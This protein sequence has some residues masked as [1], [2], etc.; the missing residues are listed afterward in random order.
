MTAKLDAELVVK[1]LRDVGWQLVDLVRED[2]ADLIEQQAEQITELTADRDG[3]KD[4]CK[5][6]E[7]SRDA[8]DIRAEQAN[9]EVVALRK[10]IEDAI[11]A[12]KAGPGRF[13][14]AHVGAL[15]VYDI[16]VKALPAT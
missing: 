3:Y 10:A 12:H 9:V 15:A 7:Q 1:R 11:A 13:D 4:A 6:Y 2:A 16:L 14:K 5:M 8:S